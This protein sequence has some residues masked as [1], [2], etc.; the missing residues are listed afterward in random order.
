MTTTVNDIKFLEIVNKNKSNLMEINQNINESLFH[1][2]SNINKTKKIFNFN[3]KNPTNTKTSFFFDNNNYNNKSRSYSD[4]DLK[5]LK[6]NKKKLKKIANFPTPT[7]KK[8]YYK[9][10]GNGFL[11]NNHLTRNNFNSDTNSIISNINSIENVSS[12]NADFDRTIKKIKETHNKS[13][14]KNEDNLKKKLNVNKYT[15]FFLYLYYI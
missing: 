15:L 9:N 8:N 13:M 14:I 11:F 6:G 4:N 1:S 12:N 2:I 5:D 7:I 10:I 3:L